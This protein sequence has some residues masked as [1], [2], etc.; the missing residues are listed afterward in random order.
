VS[1]LGVVRKS[2]ILQISHSPLFNYFLEKQAKQ[3]KKLCLYE[4]FSI[5]QDLHHSIPRQKLSILLFFVFF[6]SGK[7]F[8]AFLLAEL[9][10]KQSQRK[11]ESKQFQMAKR[12]FHGVGWK[13]STFNFQLVRLL[14][15]PLQAGLKDSYFT[16]V[17]YFS[18]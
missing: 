17:S 8:Q 2:Q 11:R 9:R 12:Y 13:H 15:D 3:E 1:E 5:F 6:S 14:R 4:F 7:R 18:F 10:I 16:V